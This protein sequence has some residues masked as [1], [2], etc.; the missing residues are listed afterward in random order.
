MGLR[1]KEHLSIRI[2]LTYCVLSCKYRDETGEGSPFTLDDVDMDSERPIRSPSVSDEM[3]FS[4][5]S[6]EIQEYEMNYNVGKLQQIQSKPKKE[7]KQV[8]MLRE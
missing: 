4:P 3:P 5:T 7:L 2:R 1:I 8:C 6:R